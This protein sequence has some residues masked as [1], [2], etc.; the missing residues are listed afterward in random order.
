MRVTSL[1]AICFRTAIACE[2]FISKDSL[3]VLFLL[4]SNASWNAFSVSSTSFTFAAYLHSKGKGTPVVYK[5][6]SLKE[7]S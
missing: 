2:G 3:F 7:T 4:G 5:S 6:A 1:I